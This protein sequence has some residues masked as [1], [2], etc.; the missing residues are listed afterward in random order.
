[1]HRLRFE[2]R[3]FDAPVCS[4]LASSDEDG[5][6]LVHL[7]RP[8]APDAVLPLGFSPTDEGLWHWLSTRAL[9]FNRLYADRLCL[10]MGIR[11]GDVQRILA[12]S[13]GL[14]LNDCYWVVPEEF[15]GRFAAYNLYQNPFSEVLGAIAYTGH[16]DLGSSPLHGLTPELT[17]GG[18]LRK[19]WRIQENKRLLYKGSTPGWDPGEWLS[20]CLVSQVARA[21]DLHHV[22]YEA[23]RWEETTCSVCSC[24][25][26][27]ETSY[28]PLAVACGDNRFATAL[29]YVESLG[30]EALERFADMWVLDALVCNTD[31]HLTNVGVLV[32]AADGRV[33]GMAPIFDNGRALFPNV[34]DDQVSDAPLLAR[35]LR[36]AV[37]GASFE[38]AAARVMGERQRER[39][40]SLADFEF[41]EIELKGEDDDAARA[42]ASRARAL[43][44]FVR[45]R[46]RELARIEPVDRA[47][48][49][50][51]CQ[52]YRER[53][54]GQGR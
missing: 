11:P 19:A 27:V 24:F 22:A 14:S 5:I 49:H 6:P 28:A 29:A 47:E 12:V 1:M 13:Y 52:A 40:Q 26:S 3:H 54:A 33:Q 15:E 39:L 8:P 7:E 53:R 36:P 35:L 34:S 48:L 23:R 42:R 30:E 37:G 32:N 4:F 16:L 50:D 10:M 43:S 31:R 2:I 41:A 20:E 25:C 18:T 38:Q 17:T 46:A 45:N 9:P 51:A 21:M 44:A